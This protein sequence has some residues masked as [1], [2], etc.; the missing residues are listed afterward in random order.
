MSDTKEEA[1]VDFSKIPVPAPIKHPLRQCIQGDMHL[2][3]ELKKIIEDSEISR[4]LKDFIAEEL[5]RMQSNGAR[6]D[7]HLVDHGDG[8][9]S[10]Q[11]HISPVQLGS[12]AKPHNAAQGK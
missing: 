5:D 9:V 6:V 3:C 2:K 4:P 10:L 7:M 11:L 12:R 8:G 1:K